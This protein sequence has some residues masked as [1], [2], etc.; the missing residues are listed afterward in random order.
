MRDLIDQ[1][2]KELQSLYYGKS[3]ST[4]MAKLHL[5]NIKNSANNLRKSII[6]LSKHNKKKNSILGIN[7]ILPTKAVS[8]KELEEEIKTAPT[9]YVK[10]DVTSS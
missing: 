1:T 8:F 3:E 9:E 5:E 7:P 2:D 6:M 4:D 10:I